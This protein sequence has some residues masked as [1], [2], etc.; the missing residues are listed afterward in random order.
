[1]HH[2]LRTTESAK[3]RMHGRSSALPVI[4]SCDNKRLLG[5]QK[6]SA[7]KLLSHAPN[8]HLPKAKW[9]EGEDLSAESYSKV[10]SKKNVTQSWEGQNMKK[11]A[12]CIE[13]W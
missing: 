3:V 10:S 1:M 13:V 12:G 8:V 5:A 2:S 9:L 11:R 7:G 4:A 6:M